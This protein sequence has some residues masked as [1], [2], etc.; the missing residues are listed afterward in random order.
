MSRKIF[1]AEKYDMVICPCC[2][3]EGYI[4]YPRRQSCPK[5]GGFGY[6]QKCGEEEKQTIPTDHEAPG[7]L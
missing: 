2:N 5:C 3:N 1:D 4:L 6:I 7:T